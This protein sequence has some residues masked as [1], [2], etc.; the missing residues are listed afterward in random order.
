MT[1]GRGISSVFKSGFAQHA[2]ISLAALFICLATGCQKSPINGDLDGQ[3]QICDVTP[4]PQEDIIKG[5]LYYCFYMHTCQLTSPGYTI[6]RG[7]FTYDGETIMIDFP[8]NDDDIE[9]AFPSIH[10]YG[11]YTNPVTFNIRFLDSKKL[12]LEN[13]DAT[14]TMR[15][16]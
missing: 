13:S 8:S 9:T 3:W 10:Q 16:Y 15:K 7:N 12:I 1:M 5:K 4:S 6:A 11:I 2:A 14:V